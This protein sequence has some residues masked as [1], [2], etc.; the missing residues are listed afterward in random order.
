M[1]SSLQRPV[2]TS[3]GRLGL[4]QRVSARVARWLF[5][6]ACA[7]A[8]PGCRERTP[9][10]Q[11]RADAGG[12]R[13][14]V[15]AAGPAGAT[16]GSERSR[17]RPAVRPAGRCFPADSAVAPP[18]ALQALLDRS[19]QLFDEAVTP[20]DAP[21]GTDTADP[22]VS[23][24]TASL[25]CA[26]EAL[27]AF[28]RS[29]EALESRALALM[30]RNQADDLSGARDALTLA[31]ALEPSDPHTLASA[32]ELYVRFLDA[33]DDHSTI[34]LEYAR[35]GSRLCEQRIGELRKRARAAKARAA[36][37]G[38][39]DAL[40]DT[41]LLGARLAL[42]EGQALGDLGRAEESLARLEAAIALDDQAG[43]PGAGRVG[44][45]ARYERALALFDLCRFSDA[46]RGFE[47]VIA[48]RRQPAPR[49]APAN[50][51][52]RRPVP[53]PSAPS[54]DRAPDH[55]QSPAR[56]PRPVSAPGN[57]AW[58]Q[59][60]LGLTLEMLGEA[61]A[62]ERALAEAERLA[63]A[64]FPKPLA[65][66]P[67]DFRAL[68]DKE[69]AA[70]PAELRRD[71]AQVTL[72]T[73]DL[74]EIA[75]LIADVAAGHPPLSPTILGLFRGL[76]LPESSPASAKSPQRPGAPVACPPG[77][78][79]ADGS[80]EPR[81]IV[82]YRKNLLRAVRTREDLVTEIRTTLLHELGHLRGE[83]DDT[84]RDRGLE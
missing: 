57:T 65:V 61:A 6:C 21:A 63:P 72:E 75:D 28:P 64:D 46:R 47:A 27:R 26:D 50:P 20:A 8:A 59:H 67:A 23:L 43:G 38:A 45:D 2:R 83:D 22:R 13:A 69:V 29:I 80:D 18:R 32:A 33:S 76:P 41:R 66:T 62:A 77:G 60:Y 58:A 31:L 44:T 1:R 71:L 73:A 9:V 3:L 16:A 7:Q 19:A 12:A 24:L 17:P 56:D 5:L 25:V 51:D 84:L 40:R 52:G 15:D 34:G 11:G 81:S 42:L 55:T 78:A 82:L 35:R 79:A 14:V 53:A 54:P 49:T 36:G 74:P 37:A 48:A 39:A 30:E 10:P 4:G 68:V 70:L